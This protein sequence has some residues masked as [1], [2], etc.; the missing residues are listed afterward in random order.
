MSQAFGTDGGNPEPSPADDRPLVLVLSQDLFF[1]TR[2]QDGLRQMGYRV[3]NVETPADLGAKG[4][5]VERPVALT[6]P[7]IGA[8]AAFIRELTR[9]RPALML[10]DLTADS[11]PTIRW[12]Q[13]IKTSAA[14][15]RIPILAFAPHIEE[16]KLK[17]AAD[18]GA[19]EA[20]SRGSL[21]AKL[22]PLV[23]EHARRLEDPKFTEACSGRLSELARQGVALHAAGDFFEAHEAL[24]HAWME[25]EG[26]A[27]YLYRALLQVTVAHLHIERGNFRGA[28]KMLL[29]VRQWLD[30]LP[31]QCR[32]INVAVLKKRV[33]ALR[34]A[35][36]QL[37]PDRLDEISPY[38]LPVFPQ[39]GG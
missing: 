22:A 6:E 12:I 5:S 26:E 10:V 1:A 32:G 38:L 27:G 21:Q 34:Q 23:R 11:L 28:T 29:R 19:D 37:G 17:A 31:A 7:L 24:E 4:E 20:L 9:L 35:L 39:I 30:P 33:A 16:E 15:R 13:T 2:L 18:A 14:T 25:E 3:R 36:S 8:D